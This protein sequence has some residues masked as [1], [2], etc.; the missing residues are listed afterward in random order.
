MFLVARWVLEGDLTASQQLVDY[1]F[2]LGGLSSL[3]IGV[4]LYELVFDQVV[5]LIH[6]KL[7]FVVIIR[8][9]LHRVHHTSSIFSPVRH[10]GHWLVDC[11]LLSHKIIRVSQVNHPMSVGTILA[12]FA[13]PFLVKILASLSLVV[14]VR[15]VKH[16]HLDVHW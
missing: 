3:Q 1:V 2:A 10:L 13:S 7:D 11:L 12:E 6:Q 8:L 16:L 14:V 5:L 9:L 15:D 4:C